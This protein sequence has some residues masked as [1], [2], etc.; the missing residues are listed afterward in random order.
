M[1]DMGLMKR[2]RGW[3][4][5]GGVLRMGL[6][7]IAI[8]D[9]NSRLSEFHWILHL[10]EFN[11]CALS[12]A[13]RTSLDDALNNHDINFVGLSPRWERSDSNRKN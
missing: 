5:L 13:E 12:R 11:P 1:D 3:T 7:A 10:W 9:R 8:T 2:R 4:Y 6:C